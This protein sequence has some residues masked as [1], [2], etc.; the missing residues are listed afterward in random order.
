MSKSVSQAI[1]EFVKSLVGKRVV[2]I[3]EKKFADR[4]VIE[5]IGI[6]HWLGNSYIVLC[7]GNK[8]K[9]VPYYT[10]DEIE[11]ET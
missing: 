10:H 1:D 11:V 5:E 6:T 9:K 8:R 4:P 3:G 2:S 7:S